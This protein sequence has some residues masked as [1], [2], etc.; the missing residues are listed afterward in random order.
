MSA[1][2]SV[3]SWSGTPNLEVMK[4]VN[5]YIAK[6]ETVLRRSQARSARFSG[7]KAAQRNYR[8]QGKRADKLKGVV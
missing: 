5:G 4:T 6:I 3:F 2:L 7:R 8:F 1:A